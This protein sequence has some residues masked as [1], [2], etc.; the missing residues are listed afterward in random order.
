MCEAGGTLRQRGC[1]KCVIC[2]LI[3]LGLDP[4]TTGGQGI[5]KQG[6]DVAF[7]LWEKR[8]LVSAQS[9][10]AEVRD[11]GGRRSQKL[12]LIRVYGIFGQE[13]RNTAISM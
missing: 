2:H 13:V 8:T 12:S 5:F 7:N 3:K 1:E 10:A 4:G 9:T 6:N 11:H